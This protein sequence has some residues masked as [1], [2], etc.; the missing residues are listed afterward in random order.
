MKYLQVVWGPHLGNCFS[1]F[2]GGSCSGTPVGCRD[3][4]SAVTCRRKAIQ[5]N[6]TGPGIQEY[7]DIT[8]SHTM[9]QFE[10]GQVSERCGK[11]LTHQLT[12]TIKQ[13]LLDHH[14]DLRRKVARGD[15]PE[16]PSAANMRELVS[17]T[18]I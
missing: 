7:C 5:E 10:P 18:K 12:D 16:Q 6:A 9:C 17:N 2:F 15:E 3:C 11:V 13:R 4:N 1:S 14:N 8:S